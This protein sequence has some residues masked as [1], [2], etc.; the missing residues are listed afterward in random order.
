M[1]FVFWHVDETGIVILYGL[2]DSYLLEYLCLWLMDGNSFAPVHVDRVGTQFPK[3]IDED[4]TAHHANPE[5]R[6]V[7]RRDSPLTCDDSYTVIDTSDLA[8]AEI[9]ERLV[10]EIRKKQVVES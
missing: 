9:V 1:R 5:P 2:C 7:G 3:G 8:P 4:R 10:R 6:D